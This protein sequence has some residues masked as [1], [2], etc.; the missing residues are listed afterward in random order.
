[1]SRSTVH[2]LTVILLNST[3]VTNA[4]KSLDEHLMRSVFADS[5]AIPSF[6]AVYDGMV[7]ISLLVSKVPRTQQDAEALYGGYGECC[8]YTNVVE[9][10]RDDV[11]DLAR[12]TEE[13]EGIK[14]K[15]RIGERMN[16]EG[17]WGSFDVLRM[18]GE[19]VVR[20]PDLGRKLGRYQ[21][22]SFGRRP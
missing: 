14:R 22:V 3:T 4:A 13:E 17:R 9:C 11:P 7:D 20:D 18:N 19:V 2:P 5:K 12:W 16:R 21:D 10:L 1:M 8:S 6:G 15:G